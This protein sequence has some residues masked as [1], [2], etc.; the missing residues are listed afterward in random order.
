L[1]G[2][3]IAELDP[4]AEHP[5]HARRVEARGL[6]VDDDQIRRLVLEQ[7]DRGRSAAHGARGVTGGAQPRR[8]LRLD[9][10]DHE[11]TRGSAADGFRRRHRPIIA[12]PLEAD[13]MK[14]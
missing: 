10:A 8:D 6:A 12:E 9:R 14:A 5:A 1:A 4:L 2:T 11:H 13:L 7:R 3:V